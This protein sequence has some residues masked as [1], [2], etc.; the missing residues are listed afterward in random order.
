[1]WQI[2]LIRKLFYGRA[3][4]QPLKIRRPLAPIAPQKAKF[5]Y[6]IFEFTVLCFLS[7]VA[8]ASV[9]AVFNFPC[10]SQNDA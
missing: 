8:L 9:R 5:A 1:M 2:C 7:I 3:L 6:Q 4:Q 10:V